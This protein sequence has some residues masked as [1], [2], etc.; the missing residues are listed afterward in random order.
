MRAVFRERSI[1]ALQV[2]S[3]SAAHDTVGV[4]SQPCELAARGLVPYRAPQCG[5]GH[6]RHVRILQTVH[7]DLQSTVRLDS[8]ENVEELGPTMPVTSVG[9]KLNQ[10][11]VL[12]LRRDG[13]ERVADDPPEVLACDAKSFDQ[14]LRRDAAGGLRLEVADDCFLHP[15]VL[16]LGNQC[17]RIGVARSS[18]SKSGAAVCRNAVA[19]S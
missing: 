18:S 17:S 12:L 13:S 10:C 16:D 15:R 14:R 2:L 8:P 11:R 5:P 7:E 19:R 9:G 6:E 4:I 3:G 1:G